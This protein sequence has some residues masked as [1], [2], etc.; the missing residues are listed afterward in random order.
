MTIMQRRKHASQVQ[1]C[2]YRHE[3]VD[4]W[5]LVLDK[6]ACHAGVEEISM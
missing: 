5:E 3:C 6:A 1:D 4:P 2:S